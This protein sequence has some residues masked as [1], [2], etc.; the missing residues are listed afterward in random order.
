L[1][2]NNGRIILEENIGREYWKRIISEENIG[3][4]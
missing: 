4:E 1:E 2:E 3:R